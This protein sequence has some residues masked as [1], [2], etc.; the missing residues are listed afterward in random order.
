MNSRILRALVDIGCTTTLVTLEIVED[1]NRKSR[2]TVV[3]GRDVDC[4]GIS[5]VKLVVSG[6]KLN[7]N[8]V[9]IDRM[10]EGIGLVMG[11]DAISQ[12]GG[13]LI[14]DDRV[15]FGA[16]KCA[17]AVHLSKDCKVGKEKEEMVIE[18]QDF[19]TE[20]NGRAWTVEWYWKE[21]PPELR[22]SGI[23]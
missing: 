16:A 5:L 11:M 12:L 23:L 15:N 7:I 9:V 4:K 6:M 21:N 10:V 1:W 19:R 17:V 22:N 13:V 8:A 2:I 3:D 14:N 18:D 20:F